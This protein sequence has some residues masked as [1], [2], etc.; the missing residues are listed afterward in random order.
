MES[1]LLYELIGYLASVLIAFSLTR[2][3]TLKLHSTCTRSR[4]SP[5]KTSGASSLP[6]TFRRRSGISSGSSCEIQ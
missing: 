2:R 6:S 3:S 4:V 5:P 1:H